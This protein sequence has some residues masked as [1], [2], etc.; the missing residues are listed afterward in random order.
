[1]YATIKRLLDIVF[2][3]VLL[4]VCAPLFVLISLAILL[5][6]PGPVLFIQPRLGRGGRR[7][8][9]AKFRTLRRKPSS[10]DVA[11][12]HMALTGKDRDI[13]FV[14]S[15]LR[16]YFSGSNDSNCQDGN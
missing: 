14:G 12:A 5:E 15:F 10:A 9:L 4:V 13:T 1:M 8:G 16:R 7:F 11:G 3:L 6:S 2:S